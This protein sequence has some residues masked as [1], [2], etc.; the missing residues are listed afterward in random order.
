MLLTPAMKSNTCFYRLSASGLQLDVLVNNA[1]MMP[2]HG[3]ARTM[4]ASQ[5]RWEI[6]MATNCVG[7]VLLTD[8]LMDSLKQT[9]RSK[10][11]TLLLKL[12]QSIMCILTNLCLCHLASHD[13][14]FER[15]LK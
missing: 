7:P 14:V 15:F 12:Q 13:V 1:G 6:T 9:A 5:P 8:L 10:V 3:K 11:P 4:C 2:P